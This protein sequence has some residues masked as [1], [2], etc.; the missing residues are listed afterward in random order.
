[1]GA[2]PQCPG[3]LQGSGPKQHFSLAME[4]VACMGLE[5]GIAV[6]KP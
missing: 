1:M 3:S 5:G 2:L 6:W 4:A